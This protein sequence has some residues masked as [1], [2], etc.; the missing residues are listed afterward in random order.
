M[1]CNTTAVQNTEVKLEVDCGQRVQHWLSKAHLYR[2]IALHLLDVLASV[3]GAAPGDHIGHCGI[4]AIVGSLH[5]RRAFQLQW[6]HTL[7]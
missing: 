7:S 3:R 2:R 6:L 4:K 5:N 1:S